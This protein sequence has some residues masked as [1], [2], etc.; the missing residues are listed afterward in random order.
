M[1]DEQN[2]NGAGL[3]Y[4]PAY[5][6]SKE[7]DPSQAEV[8]PTKETIKREDFDFFRARMERQAAMGRVLLI[9]VLL[10][11]VGGNIWLTLRTQDIV[12]D[13]VNQARH[14]QAQLDESLVVE[15]KALEVQVGALSR[16]LEAVLQA[17]PFEAAPATE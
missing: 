2:Q 6:K 1:S 8:I 5:D 15:V 14:D 12:I 4:A 16:Q 10:I 17:H 11:A 13:N 3:S 7:F 9:V